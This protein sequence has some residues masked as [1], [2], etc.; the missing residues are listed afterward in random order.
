MKGFLI[1]FIG[2]FVVVNC[3]PSCEMNEWNLYKARYAKKYRN[4]S[5]DRHRM[6]IYFNNKNDIDKHNQMYRKRSVT[7]RLNVNKFSDL[8]PAEY[9]SQM[10]GLLRSPDRKRNV[11][12]EKSTRFHE[13][14][15][16]P[17]FV[18]WRRKGAV[19]SVKAQY[20]CSA[21]WAFSVLGALEGQYFLK[22][23]R[24]VSLSAQNL[25]DCVSD[26]SSKCLGH[27]L[28][29]AYDYIKRNG[30]VDT[31]VSYPYKGIGGIC[32]YDPNT[33]AGATL[34]GVVDIPRGD[35]YSLQR[36]I[37]MVGPISI[38]LDYSHKSF[39][40]YSSG[41]YYEPNCNSSETNHAMLAVGYGTDSRGE[42]YYILKNSWGK[43]WG[44]GGYMRIARNR[45]NHCGVASDAT[46]PIV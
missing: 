26:W 19:T 44:E 46:Y 5:E 41:I 1:V 28:H 29:Q 3:S 13:L 2:L 23:G 8:S 4:E 30:G 15:V 17:R 38:C 43:D 40:F 20:N 31:D 34:T 24:L 7:Y 18:D 6:S 21:C 42:D 9:I 16:L 27:S 45:R 25:V 32:K 11:T 39:Q 33:N 10:S 12:V 36:A 14:L 35:E 22:K 37:A